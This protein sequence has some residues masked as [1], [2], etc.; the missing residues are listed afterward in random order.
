MG[1]HAAGLIAPGTIAPHTPP[2]A[3]APAGVIA[4]DG[5]SLP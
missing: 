2:T 4:P 3:L 1:T 5:G